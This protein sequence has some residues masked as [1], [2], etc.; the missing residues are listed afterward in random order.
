MGKVQNTPVIMR[1]TP[2]QAEQAAALEAE[3][4][5][6]PWSEK[7]FADAAACGQALFYT[8]V[9][10]N[11]VV[12]YCGIYLAADEGEITNVAVAPAF[13]RLRIAESLLERL[14]PEAAK[15]GARQVFLE[16]RV[17]NTPA[18]KLYEKLNFRVVGSRK[19]FYQCPLEDALVMQCKLEHK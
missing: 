15:R 17:S 10:D 6:M 18:I 9:L 19:G 3:I 16:V 1:M 7:A 5:T 8:A 12:G 2:A 11:K 13:R 4:F 14:L